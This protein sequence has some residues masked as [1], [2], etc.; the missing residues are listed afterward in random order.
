MKTY[1]IH[2]IR[3]GLTED[4]LKGLYA[5]HTDTSLCDEGKAQILQLLDN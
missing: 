4:N 3:H 2:L 5:G 1:K